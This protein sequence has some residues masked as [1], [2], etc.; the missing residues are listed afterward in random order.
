MMKCKFIYF[1]LYLVQ[2]KLNKL[3]FYREFLMRFKESRSLIAA[4]SKRGHELCEL[5]KL[6]TV[7]Q[8]PSNDEA[9]KKARLKIITYLFYSVLSA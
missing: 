5:R 4:L 1:T 7:Y 9:R 3:S 8:K 2:C 6:G